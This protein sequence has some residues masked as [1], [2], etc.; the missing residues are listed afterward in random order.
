VLMFSKKEIFYFQGAQKHLEEI[1]AATLR[2]LGANVVL[3]LED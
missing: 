3:K 2:V 1:K